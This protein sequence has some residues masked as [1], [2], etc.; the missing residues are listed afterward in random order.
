[1]LGIGVKHT[2]GENVGLVWQGEGA[3]PKCEGCEPKVQLEIRGQS[4][5]GKWLCVKSKLLSNSHSTQYVPTGPVN[6]TTN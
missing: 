4:C 6:T 3:P 2:P 5:Q 1:M